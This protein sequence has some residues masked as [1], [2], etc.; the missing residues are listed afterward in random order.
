[1]EIKKCIWN[2]REPFFEEDIVTV[3]LKDKGVETG[4]IA[5][6]GSNTIKLDTSTKYNASIPEIDVRDI[7]IISREEKK[8]FTWG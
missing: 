4:R 5:M 6:I 8:E 7:D 1:M 2:G 3:C